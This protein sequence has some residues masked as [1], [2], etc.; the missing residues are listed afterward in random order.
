MHTWH[1]GRLTLGSIARAISSRQILVTFEREGNGWISRIINFRSRF[2]GLVRRLV[3][4]PPRPRGCYVHGISGH[5]WRDCRDGLES[6]RTSRRQVLIPRLQPTQPRG[7]GGL[8]SRWTSHNGVTAC[9]LA[10]AQTA[11]YNS[12]PLN[13]QTSRLHGN[14]PTSCHPS[15]YP[16]SNGHAE[17]AVKAMKKFLQKTSQSGKLDEGEQGSQAPTR[18]PCSSVAVHPSRHPCPHSALPVFRIDKWH[19]STWVWCDLGPGVR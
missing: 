14:S 13:S 15:H 7:C 3:W 8:E 2:H 17:V 16:R 12:H 9:P 19:M 6:R 10:S 5:L 4:I 1:V 11:A 18:R